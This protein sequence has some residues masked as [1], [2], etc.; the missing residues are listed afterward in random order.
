METFFK[1]E[2][3]RKKRRG[4]REREMLNSALYL[5]LLVG[6]T[7][8]HM[9]HPDGVKQCWNCVC[10]LKGVNP[11]MQKEGIGTANFVLL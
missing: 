2:K 9:E 11:E 1:K 4:G 7:G 5:L 10:F 3:K 8:F 6:C